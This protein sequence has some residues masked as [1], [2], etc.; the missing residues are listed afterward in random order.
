M[1][2]KGNI[3]FNV[4]FAFLQRALLLKE[5]TG[6]CEELVFSFKFRT[7]LWSVQNNPYWI[8]HPENI[9][10]IH[11]PLCLLVAVQVSV[12]W[13]AMQSILSYAKYRNNPKY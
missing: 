8:A 7:V 4:L 11:T 10:Y 12:P 13:T 3:F 2:H 6:F 5:Q 9:S 1:F